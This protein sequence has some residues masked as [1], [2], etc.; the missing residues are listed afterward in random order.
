MRRLIVPAFESEA[1]EIRWWESHLDAVE[2]NLA[3]GIQNGV[4]RRG[5]TAR[6][7]SDARKRLAGVFRHVTIRILEEDLELAREQAMENGIS[8]QS[9]I[10]SVLHEALLKRRRR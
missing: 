9:Y 3:E 5:A 8:H 6:I 2:E 4:A 1:E 7:L 10:A